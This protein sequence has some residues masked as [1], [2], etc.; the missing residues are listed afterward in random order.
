MTSNVNQPRTDMIKG[1]NG[2]LLKDL[3]SNFKGRKKYIFWLLNVHRLNNG[4]T[5]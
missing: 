2:D 3:H 4:K 1:E 5:A